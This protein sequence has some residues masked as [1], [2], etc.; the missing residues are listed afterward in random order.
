MNFKLEA[1]PTK[2]DD[3]QPQDQETEVQDD[4]SD[5]ELL[6]AVHKAK[7]ARRRVAHKSKTITK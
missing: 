5:C 3:H 2:Q 1:I 4:D 6:S 7:T